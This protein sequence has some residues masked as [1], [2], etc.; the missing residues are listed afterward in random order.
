M[1]S[2]AAVAAGDTSEIVTEELV[3]T[4]FGIR[5]RVV[6]DPVS[7]APMVVPIGR[8]HGGADSE[9]AVAP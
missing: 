4:A 3:T 2:G 7:C 9:P 5:A 1:R 8:Y 6:P